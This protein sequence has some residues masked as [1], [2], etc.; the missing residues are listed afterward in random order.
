MSWNI[1][2]PIT[3]NG[4]LTWMNPHVYS[5]FLKQRHPHIIVSEHGVTL[6]SSQMFDNMSVIIEIHARR[7][8]ITQKIY[9]IE[10][11]DR[12]N[13]KQL[14]YTSIFG[15][16]KHHWKTL[17]SVD[18]CFL[19]DPFQ[20]IHWKVTGWEIQ[21]LLGKVAAKEP[22][23]APNL[24]WYL[25]PCTIDIMPMF[26]N[27]NVQYIYIYT[28]MSCFN[29]FKQK[30]PTNSINISKCHRQVSTNVTKIKH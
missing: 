14:H 3:T 29:L 26:Y 10:L 2:V 20:P 13:M 16:N 9:N 18:L 12:N 22:A 21:S 7:M 8:P 30:T 25:V 17:S 15:E 11:N 27:V 4:R 23:A 28:Y 5:H 19:R 24:S 6:K 1:P